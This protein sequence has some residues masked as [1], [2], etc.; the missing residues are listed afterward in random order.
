MSTQNN[1]PTKTLQPT[2]HP[3]PNKKTAVA[4]HEAD[5]A[6][7]SDTGG[8]V[9]IPASFQGLYGIRTT[10]GR[11]SLDGACPLAESYGALRE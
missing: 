2:T 7:G 1:Q 6:L 3:P 8:S 5:A 4:A 11:V 10:H 9:R